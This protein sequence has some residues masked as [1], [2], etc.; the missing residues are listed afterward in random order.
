MKSLIELINHILRFI[1]KYERSEH[2]KKVQDARRDPAK[3]F[4]DLGGVRD[5]KPKKD[6]NS[7][8]R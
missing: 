6:A 1:F 2:E 4:N 8:K 7:T 5:D 3:Y